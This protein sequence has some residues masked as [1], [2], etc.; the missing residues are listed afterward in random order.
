[1]SRIAQSL[2]PAT[3][4]AGFPALVPGRIYLDNPGGTQVHESVL[5]AMRSYLV[6]RNANLGGPFETSVA[7]DETLA[8]ARAVAAAFLGAARR[9][10]RSCSGPT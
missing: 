5:D 2:D 4:R 8:D 6:D 7:S 9:R 10:T 3:T 1:M